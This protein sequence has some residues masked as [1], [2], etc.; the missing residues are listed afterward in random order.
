METFFYPLGHL[1]G[2]GSGSGLQGVRGRQSKG[3]ELEEKL[4]T[5]SHRVWAPAVCF[6]MY[7]GCLFGVRKGKQMI[8]R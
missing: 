8:Q 5:L 4:M 6:T 1:P 2:R 7:S 3:L